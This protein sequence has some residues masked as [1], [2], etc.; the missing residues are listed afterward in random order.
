MM[1][2]EEAADREIHDEF[3]RAFCEVYTTTPA[4]M[5]TDILTLSQTP[6]FS[7][8]K[9]TRW[10]T[11][12]GKTQ[13]G[14]GIEISHG[15]H[16]HYV[17]SILNDVNPPFINHDPSTAISDGVSF[18]DAIF[19]AVRYH[20]SDQADW[21]AQ[22]PLT[23][24]RRLT[25]L[26]NDHHEFF[27]VLMLREIYERP[28]KHGPLCKHTP[29]PRPIR[30][31]KYWLQRVG[32]SMIRTHYPLHLSDMWRIPHIHDD[33]AD[34]AQL[35]RNPNI[36]RR[37]ALWLFARGYRE[38]H[39]VH[40][41]TIETSIVGRSLMIFG[42]GLA[43]MTSE[44]FY[45][46]YNIADTF[47]RYGNLIPLPSPQKIIAD[48]YHAIPVPQ[49]QS[50][51][52]IIDTAPEIVTP[53]ARYCLRDFLRRRFTARQWNEFHKVS[54]P[55]SADQ[56]TTAGLVCCDTADNIFGNFGPSITA[57]FNPNIDTCRMLE[58]LHHDY[59]YQTIAGSLLARL[60]PPRAYDWRSERVI[61]YHLPTTVITVLSQHI[62]ETRTNELRRKYTVPAECK[63]RV[64]ER[65]YDR[66]IISERRVAEL[67]AIIVL[68]CD[69]YLVME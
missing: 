51:D 20:I 25:L 32:L 9:Q 17:L 6:I 16:N 62:D 43:P 19:H 61:T 59:S 7:P 38:F 55:P 37:L 47:F 13:A 63:L 5:Q 64:L 58:L 3:I 57:L 27:A 2:S 53:R 22:T 14:G 4:R 44:H 23:Q 39:W 34:G 1:M 12:A 36:S 30:S 54:A 67:F 49:H 45:A 42:H 56:R 46:A 15:E 60:G 29:P 33:Q 65:R 48:G 21:D 11:R 24:Q 69:Q 52:S 10:G 68:M 66:E 8:Y 50:I 41:E 18:A 40:H 31:W 26:K 28:C 35:A